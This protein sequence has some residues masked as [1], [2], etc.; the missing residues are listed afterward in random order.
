MN[1]SG[2]VLHNADIDSPWWSKMPPA[3]CRCYLWDC[4]RYGSNSAVTYTVS[5]RIWIIFYPCHKIAP[6]WKSIQ[7]KPPLHNQVQWRLLVMF[8]LIFAYL[9]YHLWPQFWHTHTDLW[10]CFSFCFFGAKIFIII[11]G[12]VKHSHQIGSHHH[13]IHNHQTTPWCLF[14][15]SVSVTIWTFTFSLPQTGHFI[16]FAS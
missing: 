14:F 9:S 11:A 15:S 12:M 13:P 1:T 5:A 4:F 16:L 3:S 6:F 10:R 7:K 8:C 2:M